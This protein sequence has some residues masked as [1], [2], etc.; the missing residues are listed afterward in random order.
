MNLLDIIF[1]GIGV[2]VDAFVI[3]IYKGINSK[4]TL[5]M[6]FFC[7]S[8]FAFFQ[9]VMPIVGFYLGNAFNEQIASF[10]HYIVSILLLIFG[11][12]L[13]KESFEKKEQ[14]ENTKI[15][16]VLLPAFLSSFDSLGVGLSLGL[17]DANLWVAIFV[18]SILTFLFGFFG[19][20]VGKFS[21]KKNKKLVSL[22]GGI[23][24]ICLGIKFLFK[25][26]K[27]YNFI[28]FFLGQW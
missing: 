5:K 1:L 8:C 9:F 2:S 19:V 25:S 26:W 7:G 28:E 17:L 14:K 16:S 15:F 3:G 23:I 12:K 20:F 21:G 22:I 4:H 18:I 13:I 6:A 11:I 27:H 24:L 10:D